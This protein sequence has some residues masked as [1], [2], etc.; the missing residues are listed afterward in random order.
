MFVEITLIQKT[1]LPLENPS[2]AAAT[3][4]TSILISSGIGSLLSH[5]ISGLRSPSIT[6]V[7]ALLIVAYSIFLPTILGIISPYSIP[8]K[9]I[10]VFF[11]LMPL[12][13]LMGIPFPTG[14][15]ILSEENK[16][17]IP[18]AWA[19]NGC[20]SVLSPILT[21]MLAMAIGFKMVLWLG[22]LVYTMAFIT[23]RSFLKKST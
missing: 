2:Y 7:I 15:K 23:L 11:T 14:L 21:I 8:V 6:T 13:L 3:V 22:A 10:S 1:I 20:F 17:L 19:I 12:G 16:S 5:R 9:I 18:W 4:L